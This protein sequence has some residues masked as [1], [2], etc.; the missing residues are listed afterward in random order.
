MKACSAVL[1]HLRKKL[2]RQRYTPPAGLCKI[3][4]SMSYSMPPHFSIVIP[5]YQR[6][7]GLHNCLTAIAALPTLESGIEV[8]VVDDGSTSNTNEVTEPFK[9]ELKLTLIQQENQGPASA[10]NAGARLARGD[11]LVFIDDDCVPESHW[12]ER[13]DSRLHEEPRL[14]VGGRCNNIL[15]DSIYSIAQQMLM[16]YLSFLIREAGPCG[17]ALPAASDLPNGTHGW[18]PG[19]DFLARRG[20]LVSWQAYAA[21]G[22]EPQFQHQQIPQQ[23]TGMRLLGRLSFDQGLYPPRVEQTAFAG[24]LAKQDVVQHFLQRAIQPRCQWQAK[25]PF[26]PVQRGR[27]HQ[28]PECASQNPFPDVAAKV[29]PAGNR[30]HKSSEFVIEE[31]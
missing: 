28:A 9:A 6:P 27:F 21:R 26:L 22:A 18:L 4:G 2:K 7:D 19:R 20:F 31:G 30:S 29:V 12:L 24:L 17:R 23:V 14:A 13:I 15:V 8:I 5:T 10:R 3:R 16:D 25:A 11:Y 1:V